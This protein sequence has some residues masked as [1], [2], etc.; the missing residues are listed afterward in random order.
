M[1][2]EFDAITQIKNLAKRLGKQLVF[3]EGGNHITAHPFG[4]EPSYGQAIIDLHRDTAIYNLYNEWFSRIKH[5]KK[6]MNLCCVK[7]SLLSQIG[8]RAMGAGACL[9]PLS[10]YSCYKTI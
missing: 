6:E 4:V 10:R 8:V 7:I 9:S 2:F 1:N 3:Y 5:C